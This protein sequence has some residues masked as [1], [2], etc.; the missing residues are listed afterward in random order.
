MMKASITKKVLTGALALSLVMAPVMTVGATTTKGST[1]SVVDEATESSPSSIPT[2]SSVGGVKTT[3]AG[4]YMAT[5]VNGMAVTTGVASIASGYGLASNEKPY[6]K[7][8][9]LDVKKSPLA[10]AAIDAAAASQGA[11]VGPMLN[12]ELGK[13]AAGKY[14][15][16]P[17]DGPAIRISLGIPKNFLQSGATYAVV[18]VRAGGATSILPNV[19]E[20][21]G[22][23]AFDI[24]GGAGAYAIIRY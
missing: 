10:K 6:S 2:T 4:I 15:L 5:N 13:M 9:N 20:K 7:F 19:S 3:T 12:I 11:T 16:L 14:S 18:C 24:T 1:K 23:I 17:S 21:E 22:T 8:S